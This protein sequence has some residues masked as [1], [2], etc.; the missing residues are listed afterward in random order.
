MLSRISGV[1]NQLDWIGVVDIRARIYLD[2]F[3]K[4]RK[5]Y[6]VIMSRFSIYTDSDNRGCRLCVH[7]SQTFDIEK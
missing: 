3:D 4:L 2:I 7:L 5:H 1:L 6:Y